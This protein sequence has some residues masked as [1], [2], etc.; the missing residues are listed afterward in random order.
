MISTT[1]SGTMA[2]AQEAP[3]SDTLAIKDIVVT[4]QRKSENLQ[5]VP[6]SVL[7]VSEEQL[8][9]SGVV[10]TA[11]LP[12]ITP[13]LVYT[14]GVGFGYPYLRGIGSSGNGPGQ[15]NSVAVY[16]DG[17]YIATKLSGVTDLTNIERVEVLKGPQGTLFGRNATGGLIQVITKDPPK[18][19]SMMVR[20][21]YDNYDTVTA[22]GYVGVPLSDNVGM[23]IAINYQNQGEGWGTNL[24][25]GE[26]VNLE[27]KFSARSKIV[28]RLGELTK[29]TLS[30]DYSFRDSSIGTTY[31]YLDGAVGVGGYVFPA[32][33]GDYDNTSAYDVGLKGRASGLSLT[34]DHDAGFANLMSIS[35]WR[36]SKYFLLADNNLDGQPSAA[37]SA[38]NREQQFS[39]EF[40][41]SSPSGRSLQWTFGLYGFWYKGNQ[42]LAL[43]GNSRPLQ[44]QVNGIQKAQS[45]A[46]Y[47]QATQELWEGGR[48]TAGL[49][50]TWERRTLEGRFSFA[51]PI[52]RQMA[53][54]NKLSWRLA[55][56]Q[57][58]GPDALVY[59]SYNRGFKSGAFNAGFL[60]LVPV[61]PEVL[62]AFEAGIKSS[63]LDR[64]LRLNLAAYYYDFKDIQLQQ[65]VNG[66]GG[67]RNAAKAEI[68]GLDADAELVVTDGLTL[69][70]NLAW[71]KGTFK[72][73]PGANIATPRID[74]NG[75]PTGGNQIVVGDV[76]GNE[77][78]RLPRIT[79]T[80]GL[81]YIVPVRGEKQLEFNITY[82]YNDGYYP[83]PDNYLR[84]SSYS[85]INAR[86]DFHFNENLKLGVWV[87]N[88]T[89]QLYTTALTAQAGGDSYAPAEPR[90]YGMT[91]E[92]KF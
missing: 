74:V 26:D 90:V 16:V 83:E 78:P 23:D 20:L 81:N 88:L 42:N 92:T 50:H 68:Y 34:I 10:S 70:G 56:D 71:A 89:D 28:A 12:L 3:A 73:F 17:V 32:S 36:K 59:A 27:D 79:A 11:D 5:K 8:V 61:K 55:L 64:R 6:I 22:A 49:R 69:S 52:T 38:D 46:V 43:I 58:I 21:G 40:Q 29:V 25:T 4:A 80:A 72:S 30:G 54:F 77:I 47:G 13:G 82:S 15:E 18:Q 66:V 65:F 63:L 86:A 48:L 7:A 31:R 57:D 91:L 44:F 24:T 41:I 67:L 37:G 2:M 53:R 84:Q 60:Q 14:R 85:L 35:A 1:L 9:Q 76:S 87:R 51:P 19:A 39:Q 33:G 62:D 45:Y 75:V